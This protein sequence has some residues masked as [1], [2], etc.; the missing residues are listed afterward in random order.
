MT[1]LSEMTD[2]NILLVFRLE[3][4]AFGVS[5]SYVHEILDRERPTMVPNADAFSPGLINVRGS[6][7]PLV[8]VRLRLGMGPAQ[9]TENARMIVLEH[10][11]KDVKTKLAFEADAVEEVFEVNMSDV[12][13]VPELGASWPQVYLLGAIRREDELIILLDPDTLFSPNPSF[14][15]A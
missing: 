7:V 10:E 13:P 12:E 5:V 1:D 15:A 6:V 2:G 11:I 9:A 4:E 8:D 3:G 14:A